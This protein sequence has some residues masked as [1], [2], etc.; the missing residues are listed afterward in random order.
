MKRSKVCEDFLK[1]NE[2]NCCSIISDSD[3]GSFNRN[4]CDCCGGLATTTYEC[5]GYAPETNSVIF[6]G[7]VCPEC[8]C[9]FYNGDD[10]EI[11][12]YHYV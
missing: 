6:L 9:Y 2:V 8:I 12:E 5:N 3:E 1:T 10:S 7:D 11:T 4:G